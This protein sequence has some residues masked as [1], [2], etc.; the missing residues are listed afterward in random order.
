[1][2][3]RFVVDLRRHQARLRCRCRS[4]REA[5]SPALTRGRG[6]ESHVS[7]SGIVKP[8]QHI[9]FVPIPETTRHLFEPL[10]A[11]AYHVMR[12]SS[13]VNTPFVPGKP[14]SFPPARPSVGR[15]GT[16]PPNIPLSRA[17]ELS[18]E[19]APPRSSSRAGRAGRLHRASERGTE[20]A[21]PP[22]TARASSSSVLI[23]RRRAAL[24]PA[25][26]PGPF[27]IMPGSASST[28]ASWPAS[29]PG[30]RAHQ[31]PPKLFSAFRTPPGCSLK[32]Y[33]GVACED[34]SSSPRC[35]PSLATRS[36]IASAGV[37]RRL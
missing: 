19:A 1:M 21:R 8:C 3:A 34:I 33:L 28:A 14:I 12:W 17:G 36:K 5:T 30:P 7:M 16:G 27:R 24:T 13:S 18:R 9:S 37:T 32:Q 26:P 22:C 6:F 35:G 11:V 2:S 31:A 20:P 15:L 23:M 4:R 10:G 25:R 29:S